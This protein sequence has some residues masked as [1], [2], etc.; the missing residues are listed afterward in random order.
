MDKTSQ[1]MNA[2]ALTEVGT[3]PPSGTGIHAIDVGYG[4]LKSHLEK[5]R[6]LLSNAESPASCRVCRKAVPRDGAM[7]LVCPNDECTA[8]GHLECYASFFLQGDSD[9]LVP[10]TGTCVNCGTQLQWVELVKELSLRM[11]GTKEVGQLF[12]VRKPRGTKKGDQVAAISSKIDD[13]SDPDD[14]D[15]VEDNWNHLSESDDAEMDQSDDPNPVASASTRPFQAIIAGSESNPFVE[16]SD[17][18][19]AEVVI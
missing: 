15:A 6:K 4:G 13:S 10:T 14:N 8:V 2:T 17:W 19:D 7:T 11:R 5:A 9:S 3:H 16:D 12:K 1:S 18:D